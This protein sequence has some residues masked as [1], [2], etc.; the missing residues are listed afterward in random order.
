MCNMLNKAEIQILNPHFRKLHFSNLRPF[1][2]IVNGTSQNMQPFQGIAP[3]NNPEHA[4]RHTE[5]W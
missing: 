2:G 1:H 3:G 5:A 4:T